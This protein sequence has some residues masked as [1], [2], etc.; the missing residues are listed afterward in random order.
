M[1]I[2]PE[3]R[4]R[5]PDNWQE[6]REQILERAGNCC[7]QCRAPN[8]TVI[9]R[10]FWT[11]EGTYQMPDGMVRNEENGGLVRLVCTTEYY[12]Y[13]VKIVLTVA[14]LDH[15]PEHCDH[16][17][18]KALCQL[19]HLRY[20]AEHHRINAWKTRHAR[21]AVADLFGD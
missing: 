19:H 9:K 17:N 5:Y 12:G 6:I 14:H 13:A 21:K 7:E 20:D 18:L 3:N 10:G 15:V 2:K 4:A 16:S 8:H 1:P 11:D